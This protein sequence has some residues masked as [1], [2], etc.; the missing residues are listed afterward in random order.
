MLALQQNIL[1][2]NLAY[3]KYK[4]IITITNDVII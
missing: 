4:K 1:N 2:T 3:E